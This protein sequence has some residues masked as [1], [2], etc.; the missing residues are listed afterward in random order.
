MRVERLLMKEFEGIENCNSDVRAAIINFGYNLC[1]GD[2]DLAF[3]FISNIQRFILYLN[4]ALIITV[5]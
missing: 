4:Y 1:L 5:I 3:N 2:L